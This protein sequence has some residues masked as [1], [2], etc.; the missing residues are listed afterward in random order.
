M[1]PLHKMGVFPSYIYSTGHSG[2]SFPGFLNPARVQFSGRTRFLAQLMTKVRSGRKI[3][4]DSTQE[5]VGKI[6]ID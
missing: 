3:L 6:N 4:R 5:K 2:S 1:G